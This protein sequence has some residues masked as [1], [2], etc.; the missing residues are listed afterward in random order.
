MKNRALKTDSG[1][2]SRWDHEKD[3]L[4]TPQQLADMLSLPLS[5][6]YDMRYRG[7][8]PRALKLNDKALRFR[9]SDVQAWLASRETTSSADV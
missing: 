3:P 6:I 1:Q 8:G 5:S 4:L 2:E 9:L 7:M